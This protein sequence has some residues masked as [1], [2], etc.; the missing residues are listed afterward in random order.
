MK[1]PYVLVFFKIHPKCPTAQIE[2]FENEATIVDVQQQQGGCLTHHRFN[3]PDETHKFDAFTGA[4]YWAM[5]LGE[6]NKATEIRTTV[7]NIMGL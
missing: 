1:M 3:L 5:V 6:N 7:K 2:C 4:L